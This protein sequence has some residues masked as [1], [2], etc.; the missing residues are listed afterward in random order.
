[1]S[2]ANVDDTLKE[3]NLPTVSQTPTVLFILTAT[4]IFVAEAGR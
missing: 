3:P 1:M 2:T 4:A